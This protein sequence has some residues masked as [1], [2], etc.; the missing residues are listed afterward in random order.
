[1]HKSQINTPMRKHKFSS[2]I[3][4]LGIIFDDSKYDSPATIHESKMKKHNVNHTNW[5]QNKLA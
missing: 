2:Y 4:K 3:T 1:M 5:M